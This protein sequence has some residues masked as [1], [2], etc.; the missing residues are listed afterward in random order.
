MV[1]KFVSS[2]KAD[3]IKTDVLIVGTGPLGCTF[4]R[5]LAQDG[6]KVIMI[7]SGPQLSARPGRHMLN[8]FINQQMT[9]L[10]SNVIQA[11][12]QTIS[13][14]HHSTYISELS[15]YAYWAPSQRANFEN[16]RQDPSKNLPH[17]AATYAVGGMFTHWTGTAPR[18]YPPERTPLISAEEW[19]RLYPIAEKLLNVHHGGFESPLNDIVTRRLQE[20]LKDRLEDG[21]PV[22]HSPLGCER[23]EDNPHYVHWT[24]A[25]TI[26]GP[27]LDEPEEYTSDRFTILP[28]HRAH[29]LVSNGGKIEYAVVQDLAQ[30]RTFDIYADTFIV[31]GGPLLT[32]QLLWKSGIRPWALGRFLNENPNSGCKVIYNR[33]IIQELRDLPDNPARDKPIPIPEDWHEPMIWIPVSKDRSWHVQIHG[34]GRRNKYGGGA[35]IRLIVDIGWFGMVDPIPENRIVLSDDIED[36]FGMPQITFEYELGDDDRARAHAMMEEMVFA[37]EA[38][39]GFLPPD[40]LPK[41]NEQGSSL[42]FQCTVRMGDKADDS[43]VDVNSKVWGIDNL[44][45]GSVGVIPTRMAANPTLT[46]VCMAAKSAYGIVGQELPDDLAKV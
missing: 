33:D 39:G 35:D 13:V 10:F 11:H 42:H 31:A 43:V 27:L 25:D 6:R 34:D 46:A 14:P 9:N 24:G 12:L 18:Q 20:R 23:R 32:A 44:F 15:P 19:A 45:L 40:G 41:F 22:Q 2:G 3:S 38:I 4:A 1:L 7:D 16:P 36:R 17:A 26:L 30:W 8:S 29:E 28:E 37:A 21:Y 5:I